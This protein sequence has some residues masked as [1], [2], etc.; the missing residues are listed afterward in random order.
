MEEHVVTAK[1][2]A[3]N[4][5]ALLTAWVDPALRDYARAAAKEI[6]MPFSEWVGEALREVLA[7]GLVRKKREAE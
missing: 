5:R 3:N 7:R 4:N 2:P 1:H 6:E